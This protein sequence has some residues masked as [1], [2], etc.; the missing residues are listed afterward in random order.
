MRY[1]IG[2]LITIGL[3][4]LLIVLLFGGG[5]GG[6][7]KKTPVTPRT[8]TSF[9]NTDAVTQATIDGPINAQSI[10]EQIKVIVSRDQVVFQHLRGYDG[11][12][13]SQ[14]TFVNTENAYNAFLHAL[15]T[16]GFTNGTNVPNTQAWQGQCPTGSRNI[17]EIVENGDNIARYWSTSCGNPSTYHGNTPLVI[18]LFQAQ[19]PGY[20]TLTQNILL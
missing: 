9:A 3:I 8:L 13:V 4:I 10:H 1:F 6:N 15:E 7:K 20:L 17:F 16:A 5:G 18:Q 14:Q 11:D 19:V 2:F 12:V